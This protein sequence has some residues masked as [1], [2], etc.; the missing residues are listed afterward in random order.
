MSPTLAGLRTTLFSECGPLMA[1]QVRRLALRPNPITCPI[2][3][4]ICRTS[5]RFYRLM[6]TVSSDGR[7]GR[8]QEDLENV[9]MVRGG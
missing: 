6:L 7:P 4:T 5:N 2:R 8:P 9:Y 1:L 3:G